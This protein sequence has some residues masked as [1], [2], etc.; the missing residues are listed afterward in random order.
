MIRAIILVN[1]TTNQNTSVQIPPSFAL[2]NFKGCRRGTMTLTA[3]RL[4]KKP[5]CDQIHWIPYRQI[6][7]G[8]P[9]IMTLDSKDTNKEIA[10]GKTAIFRL[11]TR[12]SEVVFWRPPERAQ[13]IPMSRETVIESWINV[14]KRTR[15]QEKTHPIPRVRF[16][17]ERTQPGMYSLRENV[18]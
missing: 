3:N 9:N 4:K 10:T 8:V 5:T 13:Q 14:P 17:Q 2:V 15:T 16:L 12:Y 18:P 1:I 11:P 6:S 7:A